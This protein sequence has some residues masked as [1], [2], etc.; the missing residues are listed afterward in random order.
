MSLKRLIRFIV[1]LAIVIPVAFLSI[2]AGQAQEELPPSAPTPEGECSECHEIVQ[3]HWLESS[4]ADSVSSPT[5]QLA[6]TEQGQ[7]EECLAC[8]TTGFDPETG[9]F[10]VSSVSCSTCHNPIPTNHPDQIMP[11]DVS[12]RLCGDCHL[13]TYSDWTQSIHAQ[14]DLACIRC[15]SPHTNEIRATDTQELC[16]TCHSEEV[17]FY[18][19]TAHYEQGLLCIDCHVRVLDGELGEGHGQRE[20]SFAVDMSTCARCHSD[21]MHYPMP[22]TESSAMGTT[23]GTGIE[24]LDASVQATPNPVSPLGFAIVATLVGTALGMIL[25]PWSERFFRR[26][27]S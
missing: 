13:D 26:A 21:E 20:H 22:G 16:S 14:E 27:D 4:H 15:H 11:T 24:G 1:I 8:H 7:P 17:H 9:E 6:W 25:A 19:Y 3:T 10:D 2:A 23:G 12:S 18:S 5:F